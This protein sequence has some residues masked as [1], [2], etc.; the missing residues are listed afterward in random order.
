LSNNGVPK[1]FEEIQGEIEKAI[2]PYITVKISMPEEVDKEEFLELEKDEKFL[3]ALKDFTKKWLKKKT[4]Q[5][6]NV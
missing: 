2:I 3:Q 6:N 5:K 1:K 4:T